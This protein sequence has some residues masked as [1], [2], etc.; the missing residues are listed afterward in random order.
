MIIFWIIFGI[1]ALCFIAPLLSILYIK[2]M[3]WMG[4]QLGV[5]DEDV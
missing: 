4:K 3:A 1:V 2:Y 5:I